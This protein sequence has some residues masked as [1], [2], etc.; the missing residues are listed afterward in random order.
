[1][2]ILQMPSYRL[3][4]LHQHLTPDPACA[5][6]HVLPALS[7]LYQTLVRK[8]R[9]KDTLSPDLALSWQQS[10][11]D[12]TWTFALGSASFHDGSPLLASDVALSLARHIWP[13]A[14]SI[15]SDILRPLIVA[16]ATCSQGE[17]PAGIVADDAHA[18]LHLHLI[19]PYCP[20]LEIL[21]HPAL[22]IT[23][24]TETA[25]LGSGPMQLVRDAQ[26]SPDS[27]Q[28]LR[29][30]AYRGNR[31]VPEQLS[32]HG[33]ANF[34]QLKQALESGEV[35]AAL[36]ERKHQLR[37]LDSPELNSSPLR[38]RWVGVLVLNA[39]GGLGD[40]ALRQAL[41]AQLQNAAQDAFGAE[42]SA[43]F[44]P[45]E[46]LQQAPAANPTVALST[47]QIRQRWATQC[48]AQPLRILYAAGRGVLT[49]SLD[50]LIALLQQCQ[51]AYTLIPTKNAEQV[52]ALVA[53][54]EFD[55]VVRGWIQDFDD[56][57]QF[58]GCFEK[59][60]PQPQAGVHYATFFEKIAAARTLPEPTLRSSAYRDALSVLER[61]C[62]YIPLCRDH[63]RLLHDPALSPQTL[64]RDPFDLDAID[65]R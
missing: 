15:M 37:L 57:D 63:N 30:A 54:G 40:R 4:T 6:A 53:R 32:L 11:D 16:A 10:D 51:L 21:S 44:L 56:P 18:L 20:M 26:T 49:Q 52:Y 12:R 17:I 58:F 39:A 59:Q 3:A 35:N 62:L 61:E 34:S 19:Q 1:M 50:L 31:R 22:G 7:L 2:N 42:F 5:E 8:N 29:F 23:K 45:E 24:N 48:S 33:Y 55:I 60:A 25:V 43:Q 14:S 47:E 27:L 64:C 28:L 38:D 46:L 41:H 13:D 65:L 9:S 36:V